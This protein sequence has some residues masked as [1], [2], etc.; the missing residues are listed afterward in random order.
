[1]NKA[2]K[3]P[4]DKTNYFS[5]IVL[6]YLSQKEDLKPFYHNFPSI[7]NFANQMEQKKDF[8]VQNR[9][10]LVKI[11]K[12]QYLKV[13]THDKTKNNIDLL[14][15]DKTFTITTGH[16][17]NLFTGP[18]YFLYKIIA[19]INLTKILKEH[20]PDYNFVPIYWMATEDHD[21]KEINFFNIKNKRFQWNKDAKGAVGRLD[22]KGLESVYEAFSKAIGIGEKAGYLKQL[23]NDAYL[24][25]NNLA[26][27]TFYLANE[28]FKEEGLVI[29]DADKK[30]LKSVFSPFIKEELL[31]QVSYK[32]VTKTINLL[33][34]NYKIQVNPREIN[35]FYLDKNLRERII[36]KNEKYVV[37]NTSLSFNKDEILQELENHPEKFSPNVIM[38][39]LYQEVI[40]PNL[41]YIGGGGE[42]AYWLELQAYF[43]AVKIPF[44]MY[45]LRDSVL[46]ISKKQF[47]KME[48]LQISITDLFLP[49]NELI[50]KVVTNSSNLSLDFTKQKQF[51]KEQFSDLL[52][53][54]TKTDKSFKGAVLAQQKKQ[55]RG[56]E[57]LEKR[58]LKAERKKLNDLV[59]RVV[60]LQNELFPNLSLQER[61]VNFSEF[62]KNYGDHLIKT[63]FNNLNPLEMKFCVIILE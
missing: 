38:R 15:S 50:K 57:N 43:K 40:L 42:L 3:I 48:K 51:L 52:N 16:Q 7:E 13:T 24:K 19:T 31:E 45:M 8:P 36:F 17:L 14:L 58:L 30:E 2:V 35:L 63:L 32:N 27:A 61:Q 4:F 54:A 25:H 56:L 11:L 22:T 12:N 53:V 21:F 34:K 55:I 5:K 39:P 29:L 26:E 49:Q 20:Y 62:Y 59:T 46:L 10:T 37:N 1:L 44:P 23:F 6:D 28:L 18:L 33:S 9:K 60:N 41:A 47:K